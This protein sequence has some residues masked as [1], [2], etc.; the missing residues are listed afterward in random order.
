MSE[1]THW[2]TA[3]ADSRLLLVPGLWLLA[4]LL[5]GC[6]AEAPLASDVVGSLGGEPLLYGAFEATVE[7]DPDF[8]GLVL[9][10]GVL[11]RLFDQFLD[12]QLLRRLASESGLGEFGDPR[13]LVE[14]LLAQTP[15][16][17]PDDA[18]VAA[19]YAARVKDFQ[20]PPRVRLSQILVS[21][22]DLA[23]QAAQA[24]AAGEDFVAVA[25][26][27]SEAPN[28]Q[29]GGDQGWLAAEDLPPAFVE[30]IFRLEPGGVTGIVEAEY[31]FH[32]FRIVDRQPAR[33]VRLEEAAGRIREQL[34]RVDVDQRVRMLVSQARERYNVEIYAQNI[35]FEYVGEYATPN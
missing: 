29:Q 11:S 17:L 35:P 9:E 5:S 25:A 13:Q 32:I 6:S 4:G 23:Q 18:A 15:G 20:R 28:A 12:E 3:A 2:A 10:S 30:T 16:A 7:D 22:R 1:R 19:Y 33:T 21:E 26:R 14:A 24:L 8:I 31:G 27:L 34:M